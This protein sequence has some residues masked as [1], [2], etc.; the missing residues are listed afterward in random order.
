MGSSNAVLEAFGDLEEPMDF[1]K[2]FQPVI[3]AGVQG[4]AKLD[5]Y[6][7]P[8]KDWN[9]AKGIGAFGDSM[10]SLAAPYRLAK[11]YSGPG[12]VGDDPDQMR[13]LS[14]DLFGPLGHVVYAVVSGNQLG[15]PRGQARAKAL[16]SSLYQTYID[17]GEEQNESLSP[18][19][20]KA[21]KKAE[22]WQTSLTGDRPTSVEEGDAKERNRI[23][24]KFAV[25]EARR[26][27]GEFDARTVKVEVAAYKEK[28]RFAEWKANDPGYKQYLIEQ[29]KKDA[30]GMARDSA[31]YALTR[32]AKEQG[33]PP[34]DL[35]EGTVEAGAE[36]WEGRQ[37]EQPR[38]VYDTESGKMVIPGS[39]DDIGD[40]KEGFHARNVEQGARAWGHLGDVENLGFELGDEK[41]RKPG[42][43]AVD[44][45]VEMMDEWP[46]Y[47]FGG[48][49]PVNKIL[50]QINNTDYGD[51]QVNA[52]IGATPRTMLAQLGMPGGGKRENKALR[53]VLATAISA[54]PIEIPKVDPSKVPVK[55]KYKVANTIL[56][57]KEQLTASAGG[58]P[59]KVP[60]QYKQ[61]VAKWGAWLEREMRKN[62]LVE[63]DASFVGPGLPKGMTGAEYLAKI[64]Q[65]ESNWDASASSAVA[66]GLGQFIP[67]T[68]QALIDRTGTDAWSDDPEEQVRA[69]AELLSGSVPDFAGTM[70]HYN[71][72]FPT[73][74]D[75]P[76]GDG[77]WRYYFGQDVGQVTGG[78]KPSPKIAR[79][80]VEAMAVG[81]AY[82]IFR[83]R[84]GGGKWSYPL[85]AKGEM[86]GGPD[87]HAARAFGNWMSDNAMD[88][89]VPVNTPVLSVTTAQVTGVSISAPN[90]AG[91]PAG[92]TVYLTDK[93]GEQ[94]SYMHLES[95]D[96]KEGQVVKPGQPIGKSG[97]ANSVPHLH[98]ATMNKDPEILVGKLRMK[99][100]VDR[101]PFVDFSPEGPGS[102]SRPR[103]FTG[104]S[105]GHTTLTFQRPFAKTLIAL[106]KASGEPLNINEGTRSYA[107]QEYLYEHQGQGGIGVAAPP[108]TSNHE[109]GAAADIQL[110]PRQIE[111]LPQFGLS[112]TVVAGEPWHVELVSGPGA[113]RIMSTAEAQDA[114]IGEAIG[115]GGGFA[116]GG[117]FGS[118][119]DEVKANRYGVNTEGY[120]A[121]P[122]ASGAFGTTSSYG[123]PVMSTAA[124]ANRSANWDALQ[125]Y[126]G[127]KIAGVPLWGGGSTNEK[128]MEFP[129]LAESIS[130]G[131]KS[132]KSAAPE[133]VTVT[134]RSTAGKMGLPEFTPEPTKRK[135]RTLA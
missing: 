91:N 73:S 71:P 89:M 93:N 43:A 92:S 54:G 109:G 115:T 33:V 42:D 122:S 98:F 34:P 106:A 95:V 38:K 20:E 18:E 69:V 60:D 70:D 53:Q 48:T 29:S 6:G 77:T 45:I 3:A 86:G 103:L 97:A 78:G 40:Y 44:W 58:A 82:G 55:K 126:R 111:L 135:K 10:A 120:Y 134:T 25:E 79:K 117:G 39:Y 121:S 50:Q 90:H 21:K 47:E 87:D 1:L 14:R 112:N 56:T 24:W 9:W 17:K 61:P 65:A 57:L 64:I 104:D 67:E 68:R 31:A 59:S 16:Y 51:A 12:R 127:Q 80:L 75:N 102:T 130:K 28:L 27:Y 13:Q 36:L 83:D 124:P 41:I 22:Y 88:I 76:Y 100:V 32:L 118:I 52:E 2:P 129:T 49:V 7:N 133:R 96:V 107:R 63:N 110:T 125:E 99:G 84:N 62:G 123:A 128:P 132:S 35:E 94:Y 131:L 72:G 85:A 4:L 119:F 26:R 116:G 8:I 15:L 19:A 105:S 46:G 5:N 108:G 114:G 11:K 66:S 113:N 30:A 81:R 37:I 23:Y 74:G 101:G